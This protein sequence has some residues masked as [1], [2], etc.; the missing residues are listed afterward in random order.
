MKISLWED[1]ENEKQDILNLTKKTFG[2]VDIAKTVYFDW[3]YR[4]SPYGKAVVL[5]SRDT[6]SNNVLVGIH[7]LIPLKLIVDGEIITSSVCCNVQIHPDYRKKH[8]FSNLLSS[9]PES[10]LTNNINSFFGIP[11][12]NSFKAFINHGSIEITRLPLLIKPIKLSE[13]FGSPIKQ[14]LKPFDIFWKNTD[15]FPEIK[16]LHGNF[17]DSFENLA[18]KTSKR[19]SVTN[20]RTKEFLNWRYKNHPTQKYKIFTLKLNNELI[21]YIITKIHYIGKKKIGVILDYM[22][23][24][25]YDDKIQLQSLIHNVISDFWK[26]DVSIAI[27]T[28][29]NG[30]L[31]NK[32]LRSCGFFTTPSF[33]KPVSLHF[34]VQ[35]YDD[36]PHHAKLNKFNNWFFVFGD[37]DVF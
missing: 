31:E 28:S 6:D 18:R 2:D 26:H 25:D 19:V 29:R 3:Q 14:I 7:S 13:Y 10:A 11:N 35:T 4:D 12:D 21:G 33:L 8:I 15:T 22:V 37:Y 20:I 1:T 23:N 24:S 5:L 34:I 17:D 27:T 30:L 32:L 36:D 16:E 9:V